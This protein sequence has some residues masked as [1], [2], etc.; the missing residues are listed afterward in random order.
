MSTRDERAEKDKF[1]G[2]EDGITFE[3]LDEAML[4]WGRAKFG[5]VYATKLWRN[6]LLDLDKVDVKDDLQNFEYENHCA[7]VYDVMCYDSAK[8]ADGLFEQ[9]RFWTVQWQIQNR[10]RQRERMYCYLEKIVKGEAARQV[11]REG[12]KNMVTMRD[13]LFRRFGAGQPE[14]LEDRVRHYLLGMPDD[15]TGEAFPP[16]CDMVAKL[17]ALE[18]ERDYIMDMCPKDKRDQY[19]DGKETTLV[20]LILRHRPSEYDSAVKTVM[21]LHRFRMYSKGGDVSKITNLEDNTRVNYHDDWLPD[22]RELRK[23][24]IS[25]YQLQKRR[26]GEKNQGTKKGV[27][28]PVLPVLQGFEQPGPRQKVCYGCGEKGH[29]RGDAECTAGPNDVWSGAPDH[30]KAKEK[31]GGKGKRKGGKGKGRG[32]GKAQGKGRQRNAKPPSKEG[33]IPCKYFNFGN[34][35]C[36][37]GD[38]CHHSHATKGGKRKEAPAMILS[39]KD[40]KMKKDIVAMVVKDLKSKAGQRKPKGEGSEDE[41]DDGLYN[42]VRGGGKQIFP[43]HSTTKR[44]RRI[45]AHQKSKGV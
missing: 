18:T 44:R 38:R 36:R 5:D 16:R 25:S 28:H 15:K 45:C 24:L 6:E 21:D 41:G 37:F 9:E 19:E 14:V 11:K 35:Y 30:F 17:N 22:Y 8:Y 10:Q 32:G 27:G 39:K 31:G 40:K 43:S 7:M 29:F 34:G 26:R 20:R 33:Q 23:E 12:V 4:S 13:F 3:K 42:L 1:S 2:G